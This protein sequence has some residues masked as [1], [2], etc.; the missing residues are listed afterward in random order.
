[1]GLGLSI[2]RRLAQLLDSD[3]DF[4][5]ELGKG[6]VFRVTI[7]RAELEQEAAAG[8]TGVSYA[9]GGRVLIVDDER[10]VADATSLLL[11]I[12][13]FEVSV[14]SCEQEAL[15]HVRAHVPDLIVSDY[16]LR[17]GETGVRVVGAVR[18]RLRRTVP[19]I[20][21]TGDTAKHA[22]ADSQMENARLMSKP[23]RADDLVEAVRVGIGTHRAARSA[24]S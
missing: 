14:A 4:E 21:V 20:F 8:A 23:V 7:R 3:V 18:D 9:P 12:E 1:L 13:G 22:I 17:G 19:V 16:H 6:S 15:E 11:E 5:S 2:V 24:G 10:A